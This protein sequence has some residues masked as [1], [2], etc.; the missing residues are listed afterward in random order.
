MEVREKAQRKRKLKKVENG[1]GSYGGEE[2]VA[3]ERYKCGEKGGERGGR[4]RERTAEEE[5]VTTRKWVE[6]RVRMKKKRVGGNWGRK[7]KESGERTDGKEG[8]AQVIR[9]REERWR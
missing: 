7:R 3:R 5:R 1:A 2:H 8:G 9:V 6:K 4:Q